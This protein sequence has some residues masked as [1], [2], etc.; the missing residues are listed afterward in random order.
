[1]REK[2]GPESGALLDR[3]AEELRR[4]GTP[5]ECFEDFDDAERRL[6]PMLHPD[7]VVVACGAGDLHLFTDRIL[8]GVAEPRG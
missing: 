3:F 1:V 7:E 2:V 6:L 5:V 8:R 4:L